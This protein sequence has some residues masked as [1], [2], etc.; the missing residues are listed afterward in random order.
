MTYPTPLTVLCKPNL[1]AVLDTIT[2]TVNNAP[3][4][5]SAYN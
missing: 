4:T 3:P 5:T 2:E 1:Q